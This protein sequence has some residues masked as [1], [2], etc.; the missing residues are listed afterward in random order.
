MIVAKP[1]VPDRYWILQHNDR[2]VGNIEAEAGGYRVRINDRVETFE[3][4]P[5]IKK[6]I[7]IDFAPGSHSTKKDH[8]DNTVYG[9]STTSRPYNAVYDVKH[10]VPLWTHEP[11]S[12]SWYT[13]GWYRIKQ[14]R[15]WTVMHC[16]KLI[17]IQRY[18]YQGPFHTREQALAAV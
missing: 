10:Q 16:P 3:A 5:T 6:K 18:A 9:Y 11:R 1:V 7:G 4:L 15:S 8:T 13:A 12:R 17:V 2:K 14:G